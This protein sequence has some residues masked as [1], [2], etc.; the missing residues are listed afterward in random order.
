MFIAKRVSKSEAIDLLE[1]AP[2]RQLSEMVK[3][4]GKISLR[5]ADLMMEDVD[6]RI[7]IFSDMKCYSTNRFDA[8]ICS[9]VLEHV[10]DDTKALREL[11]RIM[12][13]GG[14]GIVMVPII[15]ATDKIDE[16]P[17]LDDIAERWRRFGQYDHIRTYSKNG[18]LERVAAAGFTIHQYGQNYFGADLLARNGIS[19]KSVLYVVEKPGE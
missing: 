2:S 6:D 9:H 4:Y 16:D 14:W 12:R 10:P 17:A 15:L 13:P 1:I 8:F 11:Y 3:S 19:N 18:W 7:D 5:T